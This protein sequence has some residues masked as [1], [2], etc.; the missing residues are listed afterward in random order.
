MLQ[1][2]MECWNSA[3]NAQGPRLII[4]VVQLEALKIDAAAVEALRK[5]E[6]QDETHFT[7]KI[8]GFLS[9]IPPW[10]LMSSFVGFFWISPCVTKLRV[11]MLCFSYFTDNSINVPDIF[12]INRLT[13]SLRKYL[14]RL[15]CE[16]CLEQ[17]RNSFTY[18]RERLMTQELSHKEHVFSRHGIVHGKILC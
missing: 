8:N 13:V 10:M 3:F 9:F 2:S 4:V 14:H 7:T 6:R 5:K 17:V 16:L 18:K 11:L 1:L 12:Q 15:L